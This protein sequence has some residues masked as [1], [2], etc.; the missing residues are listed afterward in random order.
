MNDRLYKFKVNLVIEGI[1]PDTDPDALE[2]FD[3]ELSMR[4]HINNIRISWVDEHKKDIAV[5]FETESI[6]PISI[7]DQMPQELFEVACAV[8]RKTERIHIGVTGIE[9]VNTI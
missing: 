9:A 4:P 1:D 5:S 6:G 8:L 7:R 3:N 2:K